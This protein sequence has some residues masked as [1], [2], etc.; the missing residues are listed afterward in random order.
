[1]GPATCGGLT[2]ELNGRRPFFLGSTVGDEND[3][4]SVWLTNPDDVRGGRALVP[5]G[6]LHLAVRAW[7]RT[8]LTR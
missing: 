7:A 1:M 4:L 6:T 2:L 8:A 5:L 3:Q